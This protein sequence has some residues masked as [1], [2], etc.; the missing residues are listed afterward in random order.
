VIVNNGIMEDVATAIMTTTR[1]TRV[2]GE[3]IRN[4]ILI[5]AVE[6]SS[7]QR[8]KMMAGNVENLCPL[9]SLNLKREIMM[10]TRL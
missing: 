3:T 2:D 7:R 8:R 6:R 5:G 9:I 4:Q 1:T 10:P